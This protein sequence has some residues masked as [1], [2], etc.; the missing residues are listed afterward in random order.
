[1]ENSNTFYDR[2]FKNQFNED[3]QLD[4]V[5]KDPCLIIHM[6]NATTKVQEQ[7]IIKEPNAIRHISDQSEYIKMFTIKQGCLLKYIKEPDFNMEIDAI[8]INPINIIYI[9]DPDTSLLDLAITCDACSIIE[10]SLETNNCEK[11]KATLK[12][13]DDRQYYLLKED[14]EHKNCTIS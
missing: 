10:K 12:A 5:S 11:S 13:L 3:K 2:L 9:D 7:A 4:I 1:M 14:R 6:F 8:M